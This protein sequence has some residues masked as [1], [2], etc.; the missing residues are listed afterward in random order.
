MA[1]AFL[2]WHGRSYI[3]VGSSAESVVDTVKA[4]DRDR[5]DLKIASGNTVPEPEEPYKE[6]L[7]LGITR[8]TVRIHNYKLEG[9]IRVPQ[10]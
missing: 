8:R 5:P 1:I 2:L 4:A 10:A 9:V 6:L 3:C 7:Q